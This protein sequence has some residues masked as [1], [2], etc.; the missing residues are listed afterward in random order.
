MTAKI[1][2]LDD[3]NEYGRIY[4]NVPDSA[5]QYI[6]ELLQGKPTE[7]MKLVQ[8]LLQKQLRELETEA[9]ADYGFYD[10]YRD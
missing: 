5:V 6:E 7:S 1:L 9:A 3:I 4:H 10:I 8:E 2:I